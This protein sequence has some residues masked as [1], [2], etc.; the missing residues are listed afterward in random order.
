LSNPFNRLLSLTYNGVTIGKDS[1]YGEPT[2]GWSLMLTPEAG[3]VRMRFVVGSNNSN[4]LA[5]MA[6]IESAFSVRRKQ[7]TIVYNGSTTINNFNPSLVSLTGYE[8]FPEIKHGDEIPGPHSIDAETYEITVKFR[9]P[10]DNQGRRDEHPAIEKSLSA[11]RRIRFAGVWTAVAGSSGAR[12]Q[13]DDPTNGFEPHATTFLSGYDN[14]ATW[15]ETIH[16]VTE[17]DTDTE[18]SYFSEWREHSNGQLDEER[19]VHQDLHQLRRVLVSGTWVDPAG[20]QSSSPLAALAA[21]NNATTGFLAK[22]FAWLTATYGST[23]TFALYALDPRPNVINGTVT[24]TAELWETKASGTTNTGRR[25]ARVTPNVLPSGRLEVA[26][27][28]VYM[29]TVV[30]GVTKTALTNA[31]DIT[32]GYAAYAASVLTTYYGAMTFDGFRINRTNYNEQVGIFEFEVAARQIILNQTA[33]GA[34]DADIVD[35][36]WDLFSDVEAPGDSPA[37]LVGGDLDSATTTTVKRP[38]RLEASYRAWIKNGVD[39]MTKWN[40][41]IQPYVIQQ[42]NAKLKPAAVPTAAIRITPEVDP[43]NNTISAHVVMESYASQYLRLSIEESVS[44]DNGLIFS[45]KLSGKPDDYLEQ[46]G[47]SVGSKTRT[48]RLLSTVSAAILNFASPDS[49]AGYRRLRYSIGQSTV[50]VGVAGIQTA[51]Y[52]SELV[53]E[54]LAVRS[55]SQAGTQTRATTQSATN[56]QNQGANGGGNVPAGQ[57]QP[58]GAA[59]G[60]PKAGANGASGG[61][62]LPGGRTQISAGA[63]GGTFGIGALGDGGSGG[64]SFPDF[65]GGFGIGGQLNFS[66]GG[67]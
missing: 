44:R 3:V 41:V 31:T 13:F 16:D 11:R 21:F 5:N 19:T 29:Q 63:G 37:V 67:A 33:A 4:A 23:S 65:D 50:I 39:P 56:P 53:E 30:S 35:D 15:V 61:G 51:L 47:I 6:V 17:N 10:A 62:G 25:F 9:I 18:V 59:G 32:D 27:Q 52:A 20:V 64:F 2:A 8:A 36:Q 7:L 57:N 46:H 24:Y 34:K 45:P 58:A 66:T 49:I 42:I 54:F 26:V 12:E 60:S 55:S 48:T 40:D 43:Q 14:S 38:I 22:I 28:G 1:T